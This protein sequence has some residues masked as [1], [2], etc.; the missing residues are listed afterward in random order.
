MAENVIKIDSHRAK[1]GALNT[2]SSKARPQ[3]KS[4]Q[5]E[6]AEQT[7]RA[8]KQKAKSE[9]RRKSIEARKDTLIVHRLN[10]SFKQRPVVRDISFSLDRGEAL[11]L[12][13]P[14]G[15]GKTTVFYMIT[16]IIRPDSGHIWLGGKN[17]THK[18]VYR[19]ARAG[20]SYLPQEASIFRGLSVEKNLRAVLEA[21]VRGRDRI[22]ARL[23]ELLAEFSIGHLR[24]T[25]AV[26]LSGGERR[27]VEIAR[28][29]ARSPNFILLDEP[30]AGIDP[31]ALDDIRSLVAQLKKRGMGV[32]ITDHN[33][34]ETLDL[35]DRA[36]V[37]HDGAILAEGQPSE[38]VGD[39]A[40]RRLYLGDGFD[41][42]G[43]S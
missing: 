10:K 38:I 19:R 30:F 18:P 4:A 40:V 41:W 37:I 9:K 6:Q 11:G 17:V 14:N 2:R 32:L 27:R 33:A 3:A 25:P 1:A 39:K 35:V 20:L 13:G 12:L 34:R 43:S 16:G 31:I 22:E 26:A 15:A 42:R 28:A 7:P 21:C 5:L 23:E 8:K 36:L 29:L 24:R